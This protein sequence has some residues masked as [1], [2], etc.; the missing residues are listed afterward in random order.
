MPESESSNSSLIVPSE[1]RSNHSAK[2]ITPSL[3]EEELEITLTEAKTTIEELLHTLVVIGLAI[4]RNRTA[5]RYRTAD[6]VFETQSSSPEY[7]ELKQHL[8][9]LLRLP[10]WLKAQTALTPHEATVDEINIAGPVSTP[11]EI[12]SI[13]L[14]EEQ[15]VLV[16]ATLRRRHRFRFA[17]R[18]GMKLKKVQPPQNKTAGPPQI[19]D[20]AGSASLKPQS[21]GS[22]EQNREISK[23][24]QAVPST[25]AKA[26]SMASKPSE[27]VSDKSLEE[28]VGGQGDGVAATIIA[29]RADYPMPPSSSDGGQVFQ[30]PYCLLTLP[31]ELSKT[32][33]LWRSVSY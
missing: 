22:G 8:E 5:S 27:Y 31:V 18:Q 15:K 30:C 24:K 4:R 11:L 9:F 19:V 14:K 3:L 17:Q 1:G 29:M 20:S 28:Q 10:L 32:K 12:D 21:G 16:T 6:L 13:A 26:T 7:D 25:Y 23:P 2:T 33:S